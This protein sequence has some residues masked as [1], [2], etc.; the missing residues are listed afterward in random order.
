[1]IIVA[2]KS[3]SAELD[4]SFHHLVVCTFL[5]MFTF[6]Q[7]NST[8]C[9]LSGRKKADIDERVPVAGK[10]LEISGRICCESIPPAHTTL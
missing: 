7:N 2:H 1:M 5:F 3:I 4:M 6:V 8:V 9:V 10:A